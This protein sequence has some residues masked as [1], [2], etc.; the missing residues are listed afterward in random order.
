MTPYLI[1]NIRSGALLGVYRATSGRKA[2]RAML[3]D[4]N[5]VGPV[6]PGL[7]ATP[8]VAIP[9]WVTET[10]LDEALI[11]AGWQYIGKNRWLAPEP[12]A[13][14]PELPILRTVEAEPGYGDPRLVKV[15]PQ[16]WE[17]V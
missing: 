5:Y 13:P 15:S 2:I 7:R 14:L 10:G 4:A 8:V 17:I 11:E 12:D 1:E 9:H 16:V 6:D 3:G